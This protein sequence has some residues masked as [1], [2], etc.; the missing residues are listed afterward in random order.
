MKTKSDDIQGD[1]LGMLDC[2]KYLAEVKDIWAP[3]RYSVNGG[4]NDSDL[5]NRAALG[6][7]T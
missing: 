1:V 5:D 6:E 2:S 7:F 3:D 4:S